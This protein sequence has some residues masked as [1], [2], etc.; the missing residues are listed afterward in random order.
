[1][2]DDN[3]QINT[4][5]TNSEIRKPIFLFNRTNEAAVRSRKILAPF[6]GDLGA[7]IE[8]EKDS[9]LN[10][11]SEFCNTEA[12]KKLFY[13]HKGRVKIINIIRQ[14]SC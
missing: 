9:P 5:D 12:L 1:M 3:N 14:G 2:V 7:E 8:A 11:G 10:Y 6:N 13:Y 4:E